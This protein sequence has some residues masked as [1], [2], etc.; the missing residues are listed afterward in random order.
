MHA[1][2]AMLLGYPLLALVG[3]GFSIAMSMRMWPHVVEARLLEPAIGPFEEAHRRR[4]EALTTVEL[5]DLIKNL[6]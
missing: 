5:D 6:P 2:I 3:I 4:V 1:S